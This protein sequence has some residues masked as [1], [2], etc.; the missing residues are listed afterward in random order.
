MVQAILFELARQW[1]PRAHQAHIAFQDI[2]K[3]RGFVQAELA[4]QA[5]YP[6]DSWIVCNFEEDGVA[7]VEFFEIYAQSVGAS[8]HSAKFI[9]CENLPFLPYS[10]RPIE[11]RASRLQLEHNG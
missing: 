3:L 7:F 11:Y 1:R 10:V 2:D 6:R 9:K 5:S 8:H 4:Q